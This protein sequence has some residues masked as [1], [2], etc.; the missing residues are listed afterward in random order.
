MI[1]DWEKRLEF[2]E[3]F[4]PKK[5]KCSGNRW[6][7][8]IGHNLEARDFTPEEKRAIGDWKMGITHN[9]AVMIMKNDVEICLKD[10]RKLGFWYY[11]DDER[12]Y[13]LLDMCFQLGWKGLC[14]FKKMLE[15]IRVKDYAEAEKQCV[16]SKYG[17]E[18][19]PTRA[20]RIGHLIRTGVWVQYKGDLENDGK[21]SVGRG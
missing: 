9:A 4:K 20:K 10:L 6:T 11:L 12:Q 19:T 15:A 7:I 5:Y 13:A 21:G 14:G 1:K 16:E 17:R 2:H 18:D 3:G 8:G